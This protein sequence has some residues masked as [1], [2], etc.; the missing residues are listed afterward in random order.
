MADIEMLTLPRIYHNQ[1]LE[2]R[3]EMMDRILD[4][5]TTIKK[6]NMSL[7]VDYSSLVD[8]LKRKFNTHSVC[9][10]MH[11]MLEDYQLQQNEKLYNTIK[12]YT[13]DITQLIKFE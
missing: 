13:T 2:D 7:M 1:F 3:E 11:L 12:E 8:E 10:L 4:I 9:R 6:M 5:H